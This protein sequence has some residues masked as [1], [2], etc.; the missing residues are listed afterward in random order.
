MAKITIILTDMSTPQGDGVQVEFSSE[1]YFDLQGNPDKL[2]R[3]Q[4]QAVSM[5]S[6]FSSG[7]FIPS[8]EA[9]AADA[10]LLNA[11]TRKH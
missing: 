8:D 11:A 6:A 9:R 7:T 3:A 2:T 5:L 4:R 10:A 1:S